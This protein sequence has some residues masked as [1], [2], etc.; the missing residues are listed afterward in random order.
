MSQAFFRRLSD[1]GLNA[2]VALGAQGCTFRER[3][4]GDVDA[5]LDGARVGTLDV[6]TGRYTPDGD[7]T[8]EDPGA[9]D[10]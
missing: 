1:R 7:A 6:E 9:G 2:L 8:L 4:D 3:A 5:Y 10:R